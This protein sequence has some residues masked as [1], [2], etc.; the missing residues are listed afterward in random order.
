MSGFNNPDDSQTAPE[1]LNEPAQPPN[2]FEVVDGIVPV[3]DIP[4]DSDLFDTE[5]DD[6][7]VME[8]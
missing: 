3:W 5:E 8:D 4:Q 7:L 6:D 1:G 2:T